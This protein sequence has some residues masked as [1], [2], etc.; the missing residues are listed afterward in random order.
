[1]DPYH[2]Y[3]RGKNTTSAIDPVTH[4]LF[5]VRYKRFKCMSFHLFTYN[6]TETEFQKI[7]NNYI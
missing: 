6:A 4:H 5:T 1:M 2:E 3:Q 7:L